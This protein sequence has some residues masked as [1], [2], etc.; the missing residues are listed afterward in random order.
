[1]LDGIAEEQSEEE[2]FKLLKVEQMR[3]SIVSLD[4]HTKIE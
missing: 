3:I 2:L 4:L 1:M